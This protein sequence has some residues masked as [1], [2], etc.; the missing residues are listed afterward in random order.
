MSGHVGVSPFLHLASHLDTT[1]AQISFTG[2]STA[3]FLEGIEANRGYPRQGGN[4][5]H[6]IHLPDTVRG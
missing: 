1:R 2:G 5:G 6:I 4:D 3:H